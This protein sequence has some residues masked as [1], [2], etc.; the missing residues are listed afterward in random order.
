[1]S[2]VA[3][4][5]GNVGFSMELETNEQQLSGFVSIDEM[6]GF[7]QLYRLICVFG[8]LY[9]MIQILAIGF[10][11]LIEWETGNFHKFVHFVSSSLPLLQ[12]V[13]TEHVGQLCE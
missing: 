5:K 2:G 9:E 11:P 12:A 3:M 7:Q 13:L 1:M 8:L 4:W 6:T 10:D